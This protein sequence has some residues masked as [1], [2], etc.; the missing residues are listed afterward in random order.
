MRVLALLALIVSAPVMADLDIRNTLDSQLSFSLHE[1][2]MHK[3]DLQAFDN[4]L[5]TELENSFDNGMRLFVEIATRYEHADH[6]E[7]GQPRQENASKLNRRWLMS[8]KAEMELREL[9]IDGYVDDVFFRLGKQQT[10]WGQSDGLQVLDVVNP[11]RYREFISDDLESRR[12]PLWTANVEFP[13]GDWMMQMVWMPDQSY[14]IYPEAGAEYAITSP[15][16]AP[17]IDGTQQVVLEQEAKPN[18]YI[19][20]SDYG[21]RLTG[22]VDGWDIGVS[23]LYQYNNSRGYAQQ[24]ENDVHTIKSEYVRTHILGA[25]FAKAFGSFSLRGELAYISDSLPLHS[26]Q[27]APSTVANN[28]AREVKAVLGLDYNGISDTLLSMQVF[29]S[30]ILDSNQ[31]LLRDDTQQQISFLVKRDFLN[32]VISIEGLVVHSLNDRDGYWHL[33]ANYKY[34]SDITFSVGV[35]TYYGDAWGVFGQFEDASRASVGVAYSF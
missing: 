17:T 4:V 23:Y 28:A 34:R 26:P 1:V 8:D 3:G 21:F 12:I 9:Y 2:E 32:Q 16:L 6:L 5:T 15:K 25:S 33:Y 27:S 7:P 19:K 31:Y 11:L 10:V 35:D 29:S 30:S 22:F 24:Q 14:H 18:R 20:D 13:V